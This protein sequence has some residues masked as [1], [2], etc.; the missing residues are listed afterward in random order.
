MDQD[1][2]DYCSN[3]IAP[4]TKMNYLRSLR[5]L[6]GIHHIDLS[7]RDSFISWKNKMHDSR[8]MFDRTINNYIKAFNFW[9]DFKGW[10]RIKPYHVPKGGKVRAATM[11]DYNRMIEAVRTW[12]YPDRTR[13]PGV[14]SLPPEFIRLKDILL[15]ELLFKGGYREKE[16]SDISLDDIQ[17]DYIKV[18]A[19]K[20]QK[21][22]LVF[23]F[24]SV[25]QALNRYLRYRQSVRTNSRALLL[26]QYGEKMNEN[27][28][29]QNAYRISRRAGIRFSPHMARRFYARHVYLATHDP[30][31]LR[32]QMGHESFTTTQEY[33]KMTEDDSLNVMRAEM[34]KLDFKEALTRRYQIPA[35]AFLQQQLVYF[36]YVAY[37]NPI[38]ELHC[39]TLMAK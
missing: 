11:E 29:R 15:V 7:N 31:A 6:E 35:G 24:P 16:L 32:L 5:H 17:G 9:S 14:R 34:R 33:I 3:N 38:A 25:M 12:S 23:I 8:K 37:G 21:S 10:T 30:E 1:F 19:G 28:V 39:Q 26:N 13:S 4:K 18:Q 27:G 36:F 22:R 20:G 2:Y